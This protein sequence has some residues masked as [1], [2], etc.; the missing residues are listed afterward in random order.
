MTPPPPPERPDRQH[1]VAAHCTARTIFSYPVQRHRLADSVS[2]GLALWSSSQR[3]VI[4]MPGGAEPAR[5]YSCPFTVT[6]TCMS[7]LLTAHPGG[8]PAHRARGEDH[9]RQH[10]GNRMVMAFGSVAWEGAGVTLT[11]LGAFVLVARLGPV[12]ASADL[13]SDPVLR[14]RLV[15]VA[16][17]GV[18][19]RGDAGRWQWLVDPT[20][21]DPDS[22]TGHLLRR[23]RVPEPHVRVFP[24]QTAA[25]AWSTLREPR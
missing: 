6:V 8:G 15:V 25:W 7:R 19:P 9:R 20:G 1:V 14:Y 10:A 23:L 2:L 4:I 3:A 22:E 18:R 5:V 13:V 16:S 11:Q 24:N 21:A 12:T 17:P